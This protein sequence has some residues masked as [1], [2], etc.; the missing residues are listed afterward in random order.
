LVPGQRLGGPVKDVYLRFSA[1][2]DLDVP[3]E[4]LTDR[5]EYVSE[6][7]IQVD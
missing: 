3:P 5:P 7:Q 6:I 1:E 2:P 4:F